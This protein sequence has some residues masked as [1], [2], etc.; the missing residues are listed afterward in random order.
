[1]NCPT[2][3]PFGPAISSVVIRHIFTRTT[4]G[5]TVRAFTSLWAAAPLELVP[6]VTDSGG[7]TSGHSSP[8]E[9]RPGPTTV[10]TTVLPSSC[11]VTRAL[12]VEV[13]DAGAVGVVTVPLGPAAAQPVNVL[14]DQ[15][16]GGAEDSPMAIVVAHVTRSTTAVGATFA[17]GGR[18]EMTVVDGWAVLAHRLPAGTSRTAPNSGE[19]A[20]AG[21]AT[22]YA[23]ASN[24][25]VIERT[26]L[27]GSGALAMAVQACAVSGK[28]VSSPGFRSGGSS[29][30]GSGHSASKP[31]GS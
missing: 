26:V 27:P 22:V 21:E 30:S 8:P 7:T 2:S 28:A 16:V 10:P 19:A 6:V 1:M 15:V 29:G 17:A 25:T 23:L 4:D 11:S 20:A 18:D 12:I 31:N 14:A 9:T 24:G 5:V 3:L 13:S